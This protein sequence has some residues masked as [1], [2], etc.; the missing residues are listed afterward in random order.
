MVI[1]SV[2]KYLFQYL[3]TTREIEILILDP[4]AFIKSHRDI[5]KGE[6]KYENLFLAGISRAGEFCFFSSCSH[7]LS[8]ERFLELIFKCLK[9]EG[10]EGV[11]VYQGFQS[12]DHPIHPFVKETFY[13][14]S[15]LLKL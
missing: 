1:K 10:R 3:K 6:K 11:I 14:K 7:F 8:R 9:K 15:V 12:P 2:I 5:K 4:P 13:L